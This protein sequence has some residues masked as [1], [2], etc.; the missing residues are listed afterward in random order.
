MEDP[1]D[2]STTAIVGTSRQL[3]LERNH[4]IVLDSLSRVNEAV[5]A[6]NHNS[7]IVEERVDTLDSRLM[8]FAQRLAAV[9]GQMAP[10]VGSLTG[11]QPLPHAMPEVHQQ[12]LEAQNNFP[13]IKPR[14]QPTIA[15]ANETRTLIGKPL[16]QKTLNIQSRVDCDDNLWAD[17]KVAVRNIARSYLNFQQSWK[18][19]SP[20][21][22]QMAMDRFHKDYPGFQQANGNWATIGLFMQYMKNV[23]GYEH[24]RRRAANQTN[25][26]AESEVAETPEIITPRPSTSHTDTVEP[27]PR[28]SVR[29]EQARRVT[30]GTNREQREVTAIP[31]NVASSSLTSHKV[32]TK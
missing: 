16:N 6:M 24:G 13:L 15:W 1:P 4:Q 3:T 11:F 26:T 7:R 10:Y 28:T 12:N 25:R 31:E 18:H 29:P 21:V 23:R 32:I 14:E 2:L 5:A 17:I 22:T 20:G 30:T 19:Q 27:I 9:E 8:D